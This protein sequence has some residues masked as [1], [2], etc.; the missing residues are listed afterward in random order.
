LVRK[1]STPDNFNLPV[2]ISD[3]S[4]DLLDARDS[5]EQKDAAK[6]LEV[7]GEEGSQA[8]HLLANAILYMGKRVSPCYFRTM[9]CSWVY[10]KSGRLKG[11][12]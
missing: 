5:P 1:V 8:F 2:F 3:D 6:L 9:P 11:Y 4:Q 12:V 10:I 7:M